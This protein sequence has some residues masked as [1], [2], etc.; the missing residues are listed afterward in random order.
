M[1][2]EKPPE[3]ENPNKKILIV[4]DQEFNIK[5]LIIILG[6]SCR[7]DTDKYCVKATSGDQAIASVADNIKENEGARCDFELILMDHHM[8]L[9]D[10]YE[11]TQEIRSMMQDEHLL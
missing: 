9:K 3:N 5:A 8:P 6:I 2:V 11:T 10:G 7:I 1:Y 4:D